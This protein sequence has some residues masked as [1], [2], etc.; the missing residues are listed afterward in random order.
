MRS[1]LLN[2]DPYGENGPGGLV[3]LYYKQVAAELAPKLAVILFLGTWLKG[4]IFLYAG[5][6]SMLS[7]R[8]KVLLSC[9]FEII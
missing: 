9:M 5:D 1:L 3:P 2:L 4:Q 7:L 8:K 6:Q